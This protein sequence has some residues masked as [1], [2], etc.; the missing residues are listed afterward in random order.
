M[1][2]VS[3]PQASGGALTPP[4]SSHAS[5]HGTTNWDYSVPTASQ[6]YHPLHILRGLLFDFMRLFRLS[7]L[8]GDHA[9]A[10][11]K[12]VSNYAENMALTF[13]AESNEFV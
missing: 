8:S 11:I 3:A 6:V 1:A 13:H 5:S 2:A 4:A 12:S 7:V 10:D 9:P